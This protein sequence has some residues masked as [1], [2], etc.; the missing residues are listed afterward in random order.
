MYSKAEM[1][2][3]KRNFW[4]AFS[5]A[6]PRKWLLYDTGIKD[7]SFKF[8]SDNRKS[9]VMLDIEI[10]DDQKRHACFEKLESLKTILAEDYLPGLVFERDLTLENGK[11][12]SRVYTEKAGLGMTSPADWPQIFDFFATKMAAFERFFYEFEDYIRSTHN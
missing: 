4:I 8:L 12:I 9:A 7:F 11:T 1:Q 3:L 10:K 5:E 2:Q 6:Y